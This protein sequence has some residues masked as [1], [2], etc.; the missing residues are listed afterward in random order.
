MTRSEDPPGVDKHLRFGDYTEAL[1]ALLVGFPGVKSIVLHTH[2]AKGEHPHL[3]VWWSGEKAVTNQTVRDRLKKYD[4][5]FKQMSGQNAWSFRNHDSFE[6]WASYVQGNKTHKVLLGELL[7]PKD[8]IKLDIPN[9]PATMASSSPAAPVKIRRKPNAEE[10]LINF[11]RVELGMTDNQWGLSHY[12][13]G[14]PA[15]PNPAR[16]KMLKDATRAV[17]TAT[18]GRLYNNQLLAGTRNVMWTFAD[19]DLKEAL[20][21]HWMDSIEKHL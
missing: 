8:T 1:S 14:T 21:E 20:V 13:P 5:A 17:I 19:E 16:K 2:G 15:W 9:T 12:D 4:P 3:H 7:P 10:R 6:N 11:C 18:H